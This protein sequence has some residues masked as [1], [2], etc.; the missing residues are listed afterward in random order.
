MDRSL[1][2]LCDWQ[3]W[4]SPKSVLASLL[5]H[6]YERPKQFYFMLNDAYDISILTMTYSMASL[7][8]LVHGLKIKNRCHQKE[9]DALRP[10]Y[11]RHK[12]ALTP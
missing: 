4:C 10:Q 7:H 2:S 3:R 9:G 11:L 5:H 6:Y 1:I 12:E 8:S